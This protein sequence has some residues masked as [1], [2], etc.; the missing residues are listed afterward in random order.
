MITVRFFS[1]VREALGVEELSVELSDS[2][3]SVASLKRALAD[4][5]GA[6]W[7]ETLH[8]PNLVHA[9][10]Q[11]VVRIEAAVVDGDEVAFFPPMT[12]G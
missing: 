1:M 7:D 9:L 2:I 6:I 11:R 4:Q 10:N 8:Q 5:N 12:G 3:N